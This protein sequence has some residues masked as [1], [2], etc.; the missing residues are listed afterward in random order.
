MR[1]PNCKHHVTLTSA[2]QEILEKLIRK[3]NTAGYR[4]LH[5][6]ILLAPDEIPA[7]E[8]WSDERVAAAYQVRAQTVGVMRKRLVE[9]GF[10]PRRSGRNG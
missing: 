10:R 4:I 7:K 1:K 9:E 6:Q 3:G 5:A 2:E 8:H